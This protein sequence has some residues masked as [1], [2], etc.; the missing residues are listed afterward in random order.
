MTCPGCGKEYDP[1]QRVTTCPHVEAPYYCPHCEN[2]AHLTLGQIK[3]H[4]KVAHPRM[5][6]F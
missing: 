1:E 2:V 6:D 4:M 3:A 5:V